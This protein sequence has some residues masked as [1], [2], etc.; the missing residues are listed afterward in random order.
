[1]NNKS[2]KE[3]KPLRQNFD[4]SPFVPSTLNEYYISSGFILEMAESLTMIYFIWNKKV[5]MYFI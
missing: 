3:V 2:Q 5:D 4:M 1:M